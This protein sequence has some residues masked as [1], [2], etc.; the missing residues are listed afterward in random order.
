MEAQIV[1]INPPL[2]SL[3]ALAQKTRAFIAS[4]K[5]ANTIRAY[6]ADW[7]DFLT[8]TDYYQLY[9]LP[10]DPATVAIYLTDRSSTLKAATLARRLNA[11]AFYHRKAGFIDSPTYNPLVRETF[12]G[13]RRVIGTAQTFKQALLS[14]EIRQIV[15]SCPETLSGLRD[16]AILLISFAAITRRSETASLT[17]KD[18]LTVPEGIIVT[19]ARSKTDQESSGDR[20]V[21]IPYGAD[22]ATCPVRALQRYLKAAGMVSGF[23][24]RAVDQAGRLS[25][26]GL[27]PDS[28]G[29]IIKR[30]VARANLKGVDVKDVAGHSVRARAITQAAKNGTQEFLIRR[31]SGHKPRSKS[32]D[33]YIRLGEMFTRNAASGLGL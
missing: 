19:I 23:A 11:I 5:A 31:Q 32:F 1:P 15:A 29:Y 18:I 3:E 9:A 6:R 4:S 24:F 8:F 10:A 25:P 20:K 28:V 12:K 33:R 21:G 14:P 30:A 2:A 7:A 22:E 13:I 26:H 27:H 17:V 16:K